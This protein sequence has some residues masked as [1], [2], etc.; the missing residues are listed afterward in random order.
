LLLIV[1]SLHGERR[2][3]SETLDNAHFS[4][5]RRAL[6]AEIDVKRSKH[7]AV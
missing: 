6:L 4:L 7:A 3:P 1:G 5:A 2:N